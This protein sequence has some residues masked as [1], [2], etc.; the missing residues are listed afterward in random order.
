M[1]VDELALMCEAGEAP[2]FVYTIPNYHN[3]TGAVL[4]AARRQQLLKLADE[5]DFL[6]IADEP[7]NLLVYGGQ[8]APLPLVASGSERVICLGSFAKLLAPGIRLGWM[9]TCPAL[10]E[11]AWRSVGVLDSGGGLNPLGSLIVNQ[12]LKD[13][14]LLENI[15]NL[16]SVFEQRIDAMCAALDAHL[17][18]CAYTRPAGGYFMWVQLPPTF[19]GDAESLLESSSAEEAEVPVVFTLGNKCIADPDP[20]ARQFGRRFRMSFAFHTAEEIGNGIAAL[21]RVVARLTDE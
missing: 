13:G 18:G 2:E 12:L 8:P 19:P 15:A 5:H 20:E 21:G 17:P 1:R 14:F 16:R 10:V 4:S 11:K 7:Y 9:H 6:V 3:P